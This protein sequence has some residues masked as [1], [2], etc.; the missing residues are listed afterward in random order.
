MT[1]QSHDFPRA[2]G[3]P[4]T[5]ALLGAGYTSLKQVAKALDAD[6]MKLHGFGPRALRILREEIAKH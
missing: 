2:I 3:A 6:L 5:R 1:E 4:A